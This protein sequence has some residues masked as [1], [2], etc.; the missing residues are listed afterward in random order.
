MANV[1][2]PLAPALAP[3]LPQHASSLEPS[4]TFQSSSQHK[5][6]TEP[7]ILLPT[8]VNQCQSFVLSMASSTS[9]RPTPQS[10]PYGYPTPFSRTRINRDGGG[11]HRNSTAHKLVHRN[12][13]SQRSCPYAIFGERGQK[14]HLQLSGGSNKVLFRPTTSC[15]QSSREI[16]STS[17]P[18]TERKS[19][20]T[21]GEPCPATPAQPNDPYEY[22]N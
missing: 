15:E 16:C 10:K 8:G 21:T 11:D 4:S 18:N 1:L 2:D 14:I 20:L 22:A 6:D 12:F 9:S 5:H 19:V 17:N 3:A 13:K 7:T